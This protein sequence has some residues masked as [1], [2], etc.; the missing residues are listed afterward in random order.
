VLLI[1]YLEDSMEEQNAPIKE[2]TVQQLDSLKH[3]T[4]NGV[5]YWFARD[6]QQLLAYAD[7]GN[8]LNAVE[9]AKVAC[10]TI[11]IEISNH[12]GDT[13]RMIALGHGA[14]REVP[15][16]ALTK[17]ACFLI[18]MN[19]ESSKIAVAQSQNYFANQTYKQELFDKLT[20]TQ[21]RTLVRD[22]VKSRNIDLNKTADSAGVIN[23]ALFTEAGYQGLYGGL[24]SKQVKT[25]K[26]ISEKETILDC[27]GHEE[28]AIHEFRLTQTKAK[29]I[30]DSVKGDYEARKTH[31]EV[32]RK[33]RDTIKEIGG[34]MP[35]DLPAET[36]L[37]QLQ[38]ANKIVKTLPKN[39]P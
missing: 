14:K 29:L 8:F 1:L 32:S 34:T 24:G 17:L 39:T 12:F 33:I 38:K 35:E 6:F 36:S 37:K 5:E 19:A 23:W 22:R 10:S 4:K 9:K 25:K 3:T 30:R 18:A 15:D 21:K 26:G 28:L 27:I 31:N 13:T 16:I 7:W 20:E 11:G 2:G